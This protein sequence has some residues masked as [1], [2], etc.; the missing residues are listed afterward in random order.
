MLIFSQSKQ[1]LRNLHV[2]KGFSEFRRIARFLL[3]T[4]ETSCVNMRVYQRRRR[5]Q[6][7][8]SRVLFIFSITAKSPTRRHGSQSF[9]RLWPWFS[10]VL[11]KQAK[12]NEEQEKSAKVAEI[13]A[14]REE[15]PKSENKKCYRCGEN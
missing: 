15:K 4:A 8:H 5:N 12:G 13:Q 14:V 6:V 2:Q 3:H 9:T 7:A 11:L 1:D 10:N